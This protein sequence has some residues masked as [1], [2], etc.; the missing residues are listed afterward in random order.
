MRRNCEICASIPSLAS[1]GEP[2][3]RLRR[4]LVGERILALCV[5]HANL[6]RERDIDSV[7]ELR[8]HVREVDG[9]RSLIPRRSPLDRRVFPARPEGRRRDS[10]RRATD[11]D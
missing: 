3:P 4:V 7:E 2:A 9:K 10:G 1:G 8:A 11:V 6:V 5:E